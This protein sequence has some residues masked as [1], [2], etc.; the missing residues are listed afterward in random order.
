[1]TF[2]SQNW[3]GRPKY[4]QNFHKLYFR[5]LL[6]GKK[7]EVSLFCFACFFDNVLGYCNCYDRFT[8]REEPI[9]LPAS[10]QPTN[11]KSVIVAHLR[12]EKLWKVRSEEDVE[13]I[14]YENG[15]Q[16]P[17]LVTIKN[18]DKFVITII[19]SKPKQ[20]GNLRSYSPTL[21]ARHEVTPLLS[22]GINW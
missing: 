6:S 22:G 8:G 2:D 3:P 12:R 11:L 14:I 10:A 7:L 17:E 16:C 13:E 5:I 20:V 15:I 18:G 9:S 19:K 1:M 21:H 4:A